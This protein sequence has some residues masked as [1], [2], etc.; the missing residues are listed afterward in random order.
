MSDGRSITAR[1]E[2]CIFANTINFQLDE[3]SDVT[4]TAPLFFGVGF[5]LGALNEHTSRP[6][7]G[8]EKN[9]LLITTRLTYTIGQ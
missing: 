8:I 2:G 9:D 6:Q 7:P 5:R 3:R 4:I 1:F